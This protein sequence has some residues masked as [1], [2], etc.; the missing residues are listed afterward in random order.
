MDSPTSLEEAGLLTTQEAA[1]RLEVSTATLREMVK[2]KELPEPVR[3]NRS[4]V[5]Y[6]EED[7]LEFIRKLRSRGATM[8]A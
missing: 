5:R 6:R 2:R 3:R 7:I 1:R 4:W 8:S